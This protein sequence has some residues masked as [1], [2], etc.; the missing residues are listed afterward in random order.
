M[1]DKIV[2]EL[3]RAVVI[4]AIV[5]AQ[6]LGLRRSGLEAWHNDGLKRLLEELEVDRPLR[7]Q[8]STRSPQNAARSLPFTH[9]SSAETRQRNIP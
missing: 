4:V 9:Q 6:V 8:A 5:Q 3:T 7:F 2:G 1:G